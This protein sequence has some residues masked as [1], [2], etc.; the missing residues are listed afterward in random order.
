M[1]EIL[2]LTSKEVK[3]KISAGKVNKTSQNK[4]KTSQI[5][6]K[7]LLTF[8]NFIN[9]ALALIVFFFGNKRDA[10]FIIIA[11]VATIIAIINDLRAKHSIEKLNLIQK[12][13]AKV[14][15]NGE[16][17]EISIEKI[18]EDD[19]LKFKIGDQII[20]DAEILEG[21]IEVNESFVTGESDNIKK[22]TGDKL[23]SGSFIVSG[24]C[25]AKA[26]AVGNESFISKL[27]KDAKTIKQSRSKLF[28]TIQK[29]IKIN[30][31]VIIP[32]GILL[33]LKQF[34]LEGATVNSAV[35]S[36]IAALVSM[37]PEGLVLLTS[38]VLALATIRLARKKVVV[39]DFYSIE[40]LARCDTIC[41]D[42]TGTLTTGNMKVEKIVEIEK[43]SKNK[44]EE[45]IKISNGLF[46][47]FNP[48]SQALFNKFGQISKPKVDDFYQFSSDKK[49]SGYRI[50]NTDYL[51]GAYS[52]ITNN[53]TYRKREEELSTNYRVLTVISRNKT[54][55]N[56]KILGFVLLSDEVR[57]NAKKIIE[58][59]QKNDVKVKIISG[60]NPKTIEHLVKSLD[61]KLGKSVDLSAIKNKKSYKT[62]AENYDIFARVRPEEKQSLVK[63]LKASNHTVAMTGDG[64]N[65]VL[66]M[67]EASCGI[68]IGEGADAAR[69]TADIVLLEND[70]SVLP[71]AINEGRQTIN[72]VTRSSALFLNKT[73]FATLLSVIFIFLNFRYPF[74]PLEMSFINF[75]IIGAPS[76]LL[77]LERN[78]NRPKTDFRYHILK[79]S[80]PSAIATIFA[81]I[82]LSIISKYSNHTW[83]ETTSLSCITTCF[84]GFLLML[85]ITSPINKF[86]LAV[87]IPLF[88]ITIFAFI[89]PTAKTFLGLNYISLNQFLEFLVLAG[90]SSLVFVV[91]NVLI[92]KIEKIIQS[93]RSS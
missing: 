46:G 17:T 91:S 42:K 26:T 69:K 90:I 62:L 61:L 84:I 13:T 39:S 10:L 83:E 21:E 32:I 66:A 53:K 75:V 63:A 71:S 86:R 19:V 25:F 88:M 24:T 92:L 8:F 49:Y 23:I 27:M 67:K 59:Y 85:K 11:V 72:N 74:A 35:T 48:T 28:S 29:I 73:I 2:G 54:G 38:S 50:K 31:F 68:S 77:A 1:T 37:I 93:R 58:Y 7:H 82:I 22:C 20:I 41:L 56:E 47:D 79:N 89:T 45:I 51:V 5:L 87:I 70:F 9:L 33:F 78:Y 76:F 36:T 16:E 60:D 44:I 65:D 6:K 52:F 64:V 3:E 57:K 55:E 12:N 34:S 15:R 30:S 40:T 81:I 43:D 18:V 80:V 4:T 14:I